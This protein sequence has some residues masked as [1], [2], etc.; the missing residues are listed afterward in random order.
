M[1]VVPDLLADLHPSIDISVSFGE[2]SDVEAGTFVDAKTVSPPGAHMCEH[3]LRSYSF[4]TVQ[5]P[6][7]KV[8]AF[9]E[10]ERYYTLVMVDPGI[11]HDLFAYVSWSH[12]L[13]VDVPDPK[14]QSFRTYL[15][16]IA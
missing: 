11:L 3:T 4:Q 13:A 2:G 8:T 15:H 7:L 10:D 5:E 16:W 14:R 1:H 6:T 9:H 12:A